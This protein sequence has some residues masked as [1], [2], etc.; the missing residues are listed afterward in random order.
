VQ[1][2]LQHWHKSGE[3]R[4]VWHGSEMSLLELLTERLNVSST[5]N[6]FF[7][8]NKNKAQLAAMTAPQMLRDKIAEFG[9]SYEEYF[10]YIKKYCRNILDFIRDFDLQLDYRY[11]IDNANELT[12]RKYSIARVE[13]AH[14]Y[15]LIKLV[16]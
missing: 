7:F 13:G 5:L 11:F 2:L 16:E 12:G 15:L 10:N 1:W 6:Y 3:E 4:V 9:N 14:I 8:V